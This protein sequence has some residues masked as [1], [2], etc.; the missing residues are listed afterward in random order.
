MENKELEWI[1]EVAEKLQSP[2]TYNERQRLTKILERIA[3][4]LIEALNYTAV[5]GF[6]TYHTDDDGNDTLVHAGH[7]CNGCGQDHYFAEEN[8][9]HYSGGTRD[10]PDAKLPCIVEDLFHLLA[11]IQKEEDK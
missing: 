11:E 7:T 3:P 5:V 1:A 2:Q 9:K 6:S 10:N 8:P 4:A